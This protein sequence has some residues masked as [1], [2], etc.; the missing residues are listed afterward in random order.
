LYYF[1]IRNKPEG[2]LSAITMATHTK[3]NAKCV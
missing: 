2:N 3:V 1:M